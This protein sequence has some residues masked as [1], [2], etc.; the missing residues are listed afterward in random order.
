MSL[1]SYSARPY[2]FMAGGRDEVLRPQNASPIPLTVPKAI[3]NHCTSPLEL[4][5]ES[6]LRS[7][8]TFK[9]TLEI[10]TVIRTINVRKAY[11]PPPRISQ[12]NPVPYER[13]TKLEK[14]QIER[15]GG[16]SPQWT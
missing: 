4:K 2:F 14:E 10:Q 11:S 12:N 13:K 9:V 3:Y 7:V 6:F 5:E 1:A 16:L 15:E 8:E